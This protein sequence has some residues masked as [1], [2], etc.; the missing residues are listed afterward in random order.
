VISDTI[1]LDIDTQWDLVMPEGAWPA[2]G[3]FGLIPNFERV[4]RYARTYDVRIVATTQLL[5]P[6]DPRFS[7]NGGEMPPHCLAGTPGAQKISATRPAQPVLVSNQSRSASELK[8][9]LGSSREIILE[10]SGP[11]LMSNP[12]AAEVLSGIR[13]AI[14]FGVG[15]EEAVLLAVRSLRGKGITV[16]VVQNA[17]AL[18]AAEPEARE[19]W[20]EE[21]Q[22]LGARLIRDLDVMTRFTTARH[23]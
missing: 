12:G 16:D 6:A 3:A 17:V 18:R 19:R 4:A 5:N 8:S 2:P 21:I 1:I 13:G 7:G 14:V 22:G 9:L 23:R 15:G 20:Q 10:T 11:D